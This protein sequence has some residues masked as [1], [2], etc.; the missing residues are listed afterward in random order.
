MPARVIADY[1]QELEV[2]TAR[3]ACRAVLTGRLL[4]A[5]SNEE[6]MRPAAGDWVLVEASSGV[7]R[8]HR[9][10]ERASVVRRQ[11]AGDRTKAQVVGANVDELW[12]VSSMNSELHPRRLE[13]YLVLAH[14]AGVRP[15]IVLTKADVADDA[16]RFVALANSVAGDTPVYAISAMSGLGLA[17]LE[18]RLVSGQ[19]VALVGSS[20]VGKST[21]ANWLLGD[22]V[23]RTREIRASDDEGRHTTTTRHLFVLP[24]GRGLLLDTPGIRELELNEGTLD[25]AFADIEALAERC[26]F[27]DCGHGAEPGCAVREAIEAGELKAARLVNYHKLGRE[28][29]YLA[30]RQDEHASMLEQQRIRRIHKER[31]RALRGQLKHKGRY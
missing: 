18:Q 31:S 20:G 23:Q 10:L 11:A 6:Q 24:S 1:G 25:G 2:M 12:I 26:R 21:L 8:V 27:K 3:G 19:T 30:R 7:T 14:D 4:G 22:Q 9:V 28:L 15:V 17:A 29:D 16:A 5:S 13:R